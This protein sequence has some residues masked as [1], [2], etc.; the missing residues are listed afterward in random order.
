MRGVRNE[1]FYLDYDN[2]RGIDKAIGY[3]DKDFG[4]E[5][6]KAVVYPQSVGS[7]GIL[8]FSDLS[9]HRTCR[10][11]Y[12]GSYFGYHSRYEPIKVGYPAFRR[13]SGGKIPPLQHSSRT[14]S[15]EKSSAL[16]GQRH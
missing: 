10:S 8:S 4:R 15:A 14:E 12:G 3:P 11:A 7:T 1:Y 5:H 13:L 2:L 9:H 16:S 6:H